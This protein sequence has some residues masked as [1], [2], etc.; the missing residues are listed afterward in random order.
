MRQL[1]WSLAAL[2]ACSYVGGCS[3][4]EPFEGT[5]SGRANRDAGAKE[6]D[7]QNDDDARDDKGNDAGRRPTPGVSGKPPEGCGKASFQPQRV[8]PDMMIVLDS[9]GSMLTSGIDRWAP[10]VAALKQLTSTYDEAVGFGLMTFP[11]AN[12]KCGPGNIQV[13]IDLGTGA[14][15]AKIL[16]RTTPQG[17]TPT[18]QSLGA[19]RQWFEDNMTGGPD[20]VAGPRYVLLVTDG[21]PTCP[22]GGGSRVN[23]QDKQLAIQELDALAEMGVKTFVVGYDAQLDPQFSAVLGEFA[24][25]GQTDAYYPVKDEQSLVEAFE[26]ISTAVSSC[27]FKFEQPVSDPAYLRVKVDDSE[28]KL[29]DP[30]GWTFETKSVVL[31]GAGCQMIQGR[32]DH[33]IEIVLECTPVL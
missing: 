16:D 32:E 10:S 3:A 27:S 11:L 28:L 4:T 7:H 18:G 1:D 5:S 20:S 6:R 17:G 19:A 33:K 30:D 24:Q 2:L 23:D 12:D 25:H 8:L 21:Q 13:P 15:I 31:Q 22:M 26:A 29:D 14:E 9:S